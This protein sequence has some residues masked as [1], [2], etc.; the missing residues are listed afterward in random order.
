MANLE[1]D[2]LPV[3]NKDEGYVDK[4]LQRYL[5]QP[6]EDDIDFAEYLPK[7][8]SRNIHFLWGKKAVRFLFEVNMEGIGFLYGDCVIVTN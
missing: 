1:Q 6:V 5:L 4:L 8:T 3:L 7:E 2:Q